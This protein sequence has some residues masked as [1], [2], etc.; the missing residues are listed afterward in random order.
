[1]AGAST[2]LRVQEAADVA[3]HSRATPRAVLSA[4]PL[5]SVSTI[6]AGAAAT[7]HVRAT[8]DTGV[9][10]LQVFNISSKDS[11]VIA[12]PLYLLHLDK[13]FLVLPQ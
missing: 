7:G 8:V 11:E 2:P 1:M 9:G 6:I 3:H 13:H 5:G 12:H 4:S 10:L